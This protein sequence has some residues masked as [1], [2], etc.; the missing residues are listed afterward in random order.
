MHILAHLFGEIAPIS[1][2]KIKSFRLPC[3][4]YFAFPFHYHEC[5]V[6]NWEVETK[7]LIR[8]D[9]IVNL[10]HV[11]LLLLQQKHALEDAIDFDLQQA[12]H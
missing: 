10:N 12:K 2:Y 5:S 8:S 1:A 7:S 6:L 4:R 9:Q 3:Y 11:Y